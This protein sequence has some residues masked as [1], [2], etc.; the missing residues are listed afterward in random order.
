MGIHCA[1]R[2]QAGRTQGKEEHVDGRLRMSTWHDDGQ[3]GQAVGNATQEDS[4]SAR[5]P[6]VEK[7]EAQRPCQSASGYLVLRTAAPMAY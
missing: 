4:S 2:V 1:L 3:L 5:A 7:E 6:P